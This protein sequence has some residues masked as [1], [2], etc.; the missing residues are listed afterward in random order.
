M[1]L[2]SIEKLLYSAKKRSFGK[3]RNNVNGEER[4]GE[5]TPVSAWGEEGYLTLIPLPLCVRVATFF[6]FFWA[7]VNLARLA[8]FWKS[9][10]AYSLNQK[11]SGYIPRVYQT[12]LPLLEAEAGCWPLNILGHGPLPYARQDV[13]R[14]WQSD[15]TCG[16]RSMPLDRFRGRVRGK[17]G[18]RYRHFLYIICTIS[19]LLKWMTRLNW[20]VWEVIMTVITDRSQSYASQYSSMKRE[21]VERKRRKKSTTTGRVT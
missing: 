6:S 15:M 7:G 5:L 14:S 3:R 18:S 21:E 16:L 1:N 9:F 2:E 19:I 12:P 17:S 13:S 8:S 10:S 4:R 11:K 20:H